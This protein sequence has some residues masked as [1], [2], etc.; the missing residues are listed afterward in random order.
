VRPSVR[1]RARAFSTKK[2]LTREVAGERWRA[3]GEGQQPTGTDA[4]ADGEGD[5][6]EASAS[7]ATCWPSWLSGL[8]WTR[9]RPSRAG[10]CLFDHHPPCSAAAKI[11]AWITGARHGGISTQPERSIAAF[12]LA[13]V[14]SAV[15][16]SAHAWAR[17]A[18]MDTHARS[19]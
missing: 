7:L 19:S 9:R 2:T 4:D 16:A 14:R 5:R 15:R 13:C 8:D 11:G 17:G 12:V 18:V 1:G 6:T 10:L 3:V